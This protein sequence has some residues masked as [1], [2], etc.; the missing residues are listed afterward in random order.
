MPQ[1]LWTPG[2][3]VVADDMNDYLQNQVVP[4]FAST[5][6]RDTDWPAPPEGA[7]CV[8]GDKLYQVVNGVWYVPFSR[9][10]KITDS[11]NHNGITSGGSD[12]LVTGSLT[13]PGTRLINI[14]AKFNLFTATA[15]G[16]YIVAKTGS[17][18][19]TTVTGRMAQMNNINGGAVLYGAET[20]Q[21]SSTPTVF[22]IGMVGIGTSVDIVNATD[23]SWLEIWDAGAP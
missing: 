15:S 11:T 5:T 20:V 1:K 21:I 6:E 8:I 12:F 18:T 4:Q 19:L 2:E 7:M 22:R 13:I 23:P 17:G 14:R 9:L 3:E 16:A 10:T